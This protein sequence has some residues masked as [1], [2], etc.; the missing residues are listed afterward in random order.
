M[1]TEKDISPWY[2]L[3]LLSGGVVAVINFI[4]AFKKQPKE[5]EIEYEKI[6]VEKDKIIERQQKQIEQYQR[7]LGYDQRQRTGME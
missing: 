5:V 7:I 3:F 2:D 1:S 6:I 4:K